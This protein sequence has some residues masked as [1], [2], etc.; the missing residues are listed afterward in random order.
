MTSSNGF[1]VAAVRRPGAALQCGASLIEVLIALVIFAFGTLGLAGL[2]MRTLSFGQSSMFRSQ[3][4]VLTDDVL[5]RMRANRADAK[6]GRWD[7]T[8]ATGSASITG[9][10]IY[11]TDLKDWKQLV[12]SILPSGQAA[13]AVTATEVTVTVQWLDDRRAS[14]TTQFVTKSRL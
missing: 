3:A 6:A 9:T 11:N 1:Q 14:E 5:D 4:A 12:E 13:I 10:E 2:Q 7:T 8:L